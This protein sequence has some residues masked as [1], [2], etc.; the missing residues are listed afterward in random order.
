MNKKRDKMIDPVVEDYAQI[1]GSTPEET[2]SIILGMA[3]EARNAYF[4]RELA[5][6]V[7]LELD[8]PV[9]LNKMGDVYNMYLRNKST[10]KLA[11]SEAIKFIMRKE[12]TLAMTNHVMTRLAVKQI[13]L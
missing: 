7:S 4:V 9:S 13:I 2:K 12:F 5:V 6:A 10:S 3:E 1:L 8:A 11:L